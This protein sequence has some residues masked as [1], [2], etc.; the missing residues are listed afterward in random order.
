MAMSKKPVSV[1]GLV[2]KYGRIILKVPLTATTERLLFLPEASV[3]D[4]AYVG[5]IVGRGVWV[6]DPVG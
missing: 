4:P 3:P 6:G 5:L 2:Y 1:V